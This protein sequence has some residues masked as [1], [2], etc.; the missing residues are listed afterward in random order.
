MAVTVAAPRICRAGLER[1][2]DP[3]CELV[4]AAERDL[5]QEPAC[6][7]RIVL[8]EHRQRRAVPGRP[9]LVRVALH[10]AHTVDRRSRS[11]AWPSWSG[12]MALDSARCSCTNP[13]TA[14]NRTTTQMTTTS[15]TSPTMA[16]STVAQTR[17]TTKKLRNWSM[18]ARNDDRFWPRGQPVRAV[19]I[20]TGSGPRHRK[21]NERIQPEPSRNR[22]C[23]RQCQPSKPTSDASVSLLTS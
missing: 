17:T 14:L 23:S 4:G 16:A 10:N 6:V 19:G 7:V 15:L 8:R 18:S 5:V 3:V 9:P 2:R 13:S 20:Q 1:H 11:A 12:R 21:T 22:S